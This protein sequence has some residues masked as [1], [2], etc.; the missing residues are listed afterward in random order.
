MEYIDDPRGAKVIP[1]IY[2]INRG[3]SLELLIGLSP[4]KA[5]AVQIPILSLIV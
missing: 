2:Q 4:Q 1:H 5:V 3:E